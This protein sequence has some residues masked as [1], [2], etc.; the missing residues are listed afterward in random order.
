MPKLITF[1]LHKKYTEIK[2]NKMKYI[3]IILQ[4]LRCLKLFILTSGKSTK[5][6]KK[7]KLFVYI[8][9]K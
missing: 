5:L 9:T 2:R 3:I 6:H 1:L 7:K 8:A 4:T